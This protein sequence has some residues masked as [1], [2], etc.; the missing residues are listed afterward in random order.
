VAKL[1][2]AGR[3]RADA[4]RRQSRRRRSPKIALLAQLG[5]GVVFPPLGIAACEV[6]RVFGKG[7]V[8]ALALLV[9]FCGLFYSSAISF[10]TYLPLRPCGRIVPLRPAPE[11][12]TVKSHIRYRHWW[13]FRL[14]VVVKFH[15]LEQ[16]GDRVLY[17]WTFIGTNYREFK[18]SHVGTESV[19]CYF[20]GDKDSQHPRKFANPVISRSV[21]YSRF[22]MAR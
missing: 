3:P 22:L 17:H 4:A 1:R 13:R 10:P 8:I 16:K 21:S 2:K 14:D 7:L 19:R 15:R 12:V 11:L 9:R 5:G 6:L 20:A 18:G